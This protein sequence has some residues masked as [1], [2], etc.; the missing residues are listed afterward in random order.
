MLAA[1]DDPAE[2]PREVIEAMLW[3][4]FTMDS[5]ALWPGSIGRFLVCAS[6]RPDV[7]CFAVLDHALGALVFPGRE[8]RLADEAMLALGHEVTAS[9]AVDLLAGLVRYVAAL[10]N[11]RY[12]S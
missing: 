4:S 11:F 7:E 10:R 6:A 9:A 1:L 3:V 8:R 2:A 12:A 5:N